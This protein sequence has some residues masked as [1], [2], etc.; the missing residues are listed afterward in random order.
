MS[1]SKLAS[2]FTIVPLWILCCSMEC[3]SAHAAYLQDHAGPVLGDVHFQTTCDPKVQPEFG[4][5][6]ALLHSFEFGEAARAFRKIENEDPT[7]SIAAWGVALSTLERQGPAMPKATLASGWEELKPW[8][9]RPAKSRREQ[10]YISAVSLMYEG[11]ENTPSDVRW[12][13]YIAQMSSLRRQYPEDVNASLLYALALVW[14]SGSGATG[15]AQRQ[16][17]LAILLPIFH[18]HPDN[19]GAAHYIIHAADVPNLAAI[20]LPAAREYARIA[21]A[22]P[23]ALH[24]PS[25]IFSRLGLW[26]DSIRSNKDSAQA[27]AAWIKEGKNARF[28][29]EH[30]LN[31]LEYAYLQTGD[32]DAAKRTIGQIAELMGGKDGDPWGQV[33][34]TIYYDLERNDWHDALRIQAPQGAPF[35]ESFD[36]FWIHTLSAAHLHM[37]DEAASGLQQFEQS[38]R[39][40]AKDHGW[41]DTFEFEGQEAHSWVLFSQGQPDA[42]IKLMNDAIAFEKTHFIYY[43]DV[44]ARPSAEMLGDMY[45]EMHRPT[46][47]LKAYELSLT[48]APNR[49]NSLLGAFHA[50]SLS[51]HPEIATHYAAAIDSMCSQRADRSDV[52]LAR[53]WLKDHKRPAQHIFNGSKE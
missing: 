29:E 9:A 6:T 27:A 53:R 4:Y 16:E 34:A 25:H 37:P 11:Y 24:M 1:P 36:A 7:C 51:T 12:K 26:E 35:A 49:L 47:A 42:A 41:G 50:A 32:D 40:W 5:A 17:A 21:P 52:A 45:L 22:S 19:P 31:A 18:D 30:A 33:D 14:T 23:H 38:S 10:M 44:L 13:R 43:S 28:D 39:A 20:A 2:V 46:E 8:L 3:S 48:F 15:T